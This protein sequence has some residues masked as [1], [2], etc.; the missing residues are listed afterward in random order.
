MQKSLERRSG[1]S[2][3]PGRIVLLSAVLLL[4]AQTEFLLRTTPE[5]DAVVRDNEDLV[6]IA[7]WLRSGDAG[8]LTVSA[9]RPALLAYH[10]GRSV[11]GYAPGTSTAYV[12]TP[13]EDLPGY[14]IAFGP[15]QPDPSPG[16]DRRSFRVWRKK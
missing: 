2:Y 13:A 16:D 15:S 11:E 3:G 14:E 9:T 6:A 4:A 8:R 1:P 5:M 12:V 7:Y 10:L